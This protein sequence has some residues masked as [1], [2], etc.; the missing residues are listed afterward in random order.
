MS[1]N[2]AHTVKLDPSEPLTD[3]GYE[4][5]VGAAGIPVGAASV[6]HHAGACENI[7]IAG[8]IAGGGGRGYAVPAG[9]V[10][11]AGGHFGGAHA[12]AG[13]VV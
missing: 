12:H 8:A 13:I 4:E 5:C 1:V 11:K 7:V 6:V 2:V 10:H 9:C 3:K